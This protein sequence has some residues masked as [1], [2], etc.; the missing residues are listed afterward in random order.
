MEECLR[1]ETGGSEIAHATFAD[2]CTIGQSSVEQ[3]WQDTLLALKRLITAGFPIN[4]TKCQFLVKSIVA[5]GFILC[6]D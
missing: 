3:C 6:G 1:G 2:D 4:I 5:L